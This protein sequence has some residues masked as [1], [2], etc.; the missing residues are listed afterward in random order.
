MVKY[1]QMDGVDDNLLAPSM[2]FDKI[3]IDVHPDLTVNPEILRYLVHQTEYVRFTTGG[4]MQLS[5]MTQTGYVADQRTTMT[6]IPTVPPLTKSLRFF[7]RQDG[8]NNRLAGKLYNLKIYNGG[9]LQAHYDMSTG[10][11]QDQS[12]NGRHAT[13]TGGTW[14]DDGTGGTPTEQTASASLTGQGTLTVSSL[15]EKLGAASLLGTGT[16]TALQLVTRNAQAELKGYGILIAGSVGVT[17]ISGVASLLGE[18]KLTAGSTREANASAQ[19]K[20][21]GIL[22]ADAGGVTIITAGADLVGAGK[23]ASEGIRIVGVSSSLKGNGVL[24]VEGQKIVIASTELIGSG[25]LQ[26]IDGEPIVGTIRLKAKRNLY[27]YLL[28]NRELNVN[29]KARRELYF[30]W[31]GGVDM[32]AREQNHSMFQGESKYFMVTVEGMDEAELSGATL[33]W[34]VKKNQYSNEALISKTSS[35]GISIEG[36]QVKITLNKADTAILRGRY[37]HVLESLDV[38]QHQSTLADGHLT[39]L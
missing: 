25:M 12:G 22:T 17:I 18:G 32:A 10:T 21:S 5:G 27:V 7:A 34:E 3:V 2:T 35:S 15:N 9:T 33:N 39:I 29:L 8:G 6:I 28:G 24:N 14:L 23:I 13:L 38:L 16:F 20:G 4:V 36:G 31:K 30:Q 26:I 37:Y 11:V 1:L 19:L